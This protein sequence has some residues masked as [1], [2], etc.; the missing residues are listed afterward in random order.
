MK[1]NVG[2]M[3]TPR[4]AVVVA[5]LST[6]LL[7]TAARAENL[8]AAREHFERGT[9]LYDLQRYGEAAREYELAFEAK[10]DPALLFNI[11]QAYRHA[12][13]L[14]KAIVAFRSFLRRVP[15]AEN[16]AEVQQRIN[17]MQRIVDEQKRTQEKPPAGTLTPSEKKPAEPSP[18]PVELQPAASPAPVPAPSSDRA[19]TG[20]TKMSAGIAVAAFG[21]AALATGIS[22]AVL[23]DQTFN[24][25]NTPSPGYVF[26]PARQDLHNASQVLYPTF[27]GLGGA[28]IVAGGVLL[29]LGLREK[30][31]RPVAFMPSVGPCG[32]ALQLR[33]TF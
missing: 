11:G 10:Q 4:L 15:E 6:A 29:G 1:R 28:A 20:R 31:H 18:P 12:G 5:L 3:L 8:K 22:F 23:E 16:R 26:D 7:S 21:L 19:R 27:L 14:Q 13:E 17:E 32:A 25:L 24:E 2:S 33:L 30:R 9:M